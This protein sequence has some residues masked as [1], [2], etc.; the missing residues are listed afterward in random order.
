MRKTVEVSSERM[1]PIVTRKSVST[2]RFS[3][4]TDE[5]KAASL[6]IF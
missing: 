4:G 6:V 2:M 1:L 3:T 5:N